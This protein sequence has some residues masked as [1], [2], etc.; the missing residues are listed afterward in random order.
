MVRKFLVIPLISMVF[1]GQCTKD[2]GNFESGDLNF[3][4]AAGAGY[5]PGNGNGGGGGGGGGE[6]ETAGNNLSFPVLAKD[7]FPINSIV[8]PSWGVEYN[9]TYPGLTQEEKDWLLL[10]G[11]WYAQKVEGN[12]WQAAFDIV[13]VSET[14]SF[15]DWGDVIESSNPKINRPFRLEVTLYKGLLTTMQGYVMALLEYPSSSTEVQGNN[16]GFYESNW[17]TIISDKPSLIIQNI[18]DASD[19]SSLIWDADESQWRD[20]N[21][22]AYPDTPISFGPEL[23]VGGKY[24]F[25][26]SEGG[27]KPTTA[28]TYRITFFIKGSNISF[29]ET[30]YI[31]NYNGNTDP[32]I[33]VENGTAAT[34]IVDYE[35]NLT[36]VDVTVVAGGG[37]HGRN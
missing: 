5:G 33:P 28:G 37:K 7:D 13:N 2:T 18:S 12:V 9:G 19:P 11:P 34:P 29:N 6:T 15:I 8:E 16:K 32:P 3:V 14:V 17:A 4:K 22:E 23:N 27:W 21:G 26:A 35:N 31:G 30:T 24:I 20:S 10:N 36:Y 25:G 1:L